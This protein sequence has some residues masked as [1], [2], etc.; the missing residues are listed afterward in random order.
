MGFFSISTAN[1]NPVLHYD[2]YKI[3]LAGSVAVSGL[4][5]QVL[6]LTFVIFILHMSGLLSKNSPLPLASHCQLNTHRRLYSAIIS[7]W[8]PRYKMGFMPADIHLVFKP[9]LRTKSYPPITQ[10]SIHSNKFFAATNTMRTS[11]II[12]ALAAPLG[13]LA[14]A[15]VNL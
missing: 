9:T 2:K 15:Q 8:L 14:S 3:K 6:V 10:H 4:W 1:T 13:A 5:P 7:A 12:A 11:T